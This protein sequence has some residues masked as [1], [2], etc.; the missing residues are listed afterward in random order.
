MRSKL[1]ARHLD[2]I[3]DEYAVD[4]AEIISGLSGT[5]MMELGQAMSFNTKSEDKLKIT[6]L[7]TIMDQNWIIIRQLDRI[8]KTLERNT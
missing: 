5:G 3:S 2:K 8:A 7:H 1:E 6:Y 4:C